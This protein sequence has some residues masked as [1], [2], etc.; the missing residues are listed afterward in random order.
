MPCQK[1]DTNEVFVYAL[2]MHVLR[3][4]APKVHRVWLETNCTKTTKKNT[5][6][7]RAIVPS[8]RAIVPSQQSAGLLIEG[9]TAAV[10]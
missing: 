10:G 5:S 1:L 6:R 8:D 3:S 4:A 9:S 7:D 2:I